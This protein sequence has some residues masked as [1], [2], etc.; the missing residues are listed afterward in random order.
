M[1]QKLDQDKLEEAARL[2]YHGA[3][4]RGRMVAW[5]DVAEAVGIDP[6]HLRRVRKTPQWQEALRAIGEPLDA[7]ALLAARQRI[8]ELVHDRNPS[9]ALGACK[10]ILS[11]HVGYKLAVEH[12]GAVVN[13]SRFDLSGVDADTIR[14][15]AR[16]IVTADGVGPGAMRALPAPRREAGEL[17]EVLEID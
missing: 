7:E 14:N 1:A 8:C 3:R 2:R 9:V 5:N 4:E 13:V 11:M 10:L 6:R 15:L 17:E 16:E 12:Q